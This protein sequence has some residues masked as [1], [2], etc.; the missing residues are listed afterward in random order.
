MK[1]SHKLW[2]TASLD[3]RQRFQSFIFP[4]GI[5]YFGGSF[6]TAE[7]SIIFNVLGGKSVEKS[8]LVTPTG[9]EP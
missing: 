2:A 6:G 5:T 7:T 9:V 8:N 1:R 3:N 4:G